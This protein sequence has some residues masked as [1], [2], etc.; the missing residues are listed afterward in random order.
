[1]AALALALIPASPDGPSAAVAQVA[2]R[3]I[4]LTLAERP[5]LA[6]AVRRELDAYGGSSPRA[7]LE[8]LERERADAFAQLTYAIAASFFRSPAARE[9]LDST[10]ILDE[11]EDADAEPTE[12]TEHLLKPVRKMAPLYR[13]TGITEGSDR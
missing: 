7:Y 2:E 11:Y 3:W 13:A 6:I 8:R 4:D 1:L 12:A 5:D 10:R 9:W